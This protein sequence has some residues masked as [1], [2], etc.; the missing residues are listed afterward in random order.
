MNNEIIDR[1]KNA[2]LSKLTTERSEKVDFLAGMFSLTVLLGLMWII[3]TGFIY[4]LL[5]VLVPIVTIVITAL[6][7]SYIIAIKQVIDENEVDK[8]AIQ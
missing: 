4:G 1:I 3:F 5:A 8:H 6:G 2:D 7:T